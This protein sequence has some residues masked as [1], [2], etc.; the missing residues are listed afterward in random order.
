VRERHSADFA[1]QTGYG[2]FTVSE[3]SVA[4]VMHYIAGQEEHHKRHS[5]QQEFVAFLK[6][7]HVDYDPKYIWD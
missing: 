7:N 5:F 4:A 6:K 2:V 1:W 3:S